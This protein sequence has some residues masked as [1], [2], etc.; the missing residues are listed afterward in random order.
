M[1][2]VLDFK[3][4]KTPKPPNVPA[5]DFLGV[6]ELLEGGIIRGFTVVLKACASI[7]LGFA[8]D[9]VTKYNCT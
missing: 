6:R 3:G 4:L 8:P 7:S 1:M 2:T 5:S 9:S